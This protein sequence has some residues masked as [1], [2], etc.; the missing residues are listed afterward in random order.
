MFI[1]IRV[2]IHSSGLPQILSLPA[3]FLSIETVGIMPSHLTLTKDLCGAGEQLLQRTWFQFPE[4]TCWLKSICNSSFK[5]S[6][7][8]FWP[9]CVSDTQMAH[10]HIRQTNTHMHKV[11]TNKPLKNDYFICMSV[12]PS[13]MYVHHMCAWCPWSL[14]EGVWSPG[15]VVKNDC[16]SPCR[17]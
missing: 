6:N 11:K 1:L 15:T 8:L 5:D 14:E 2:S 9:S 13:C 4:L 12:L 7:T 3:C 10:I 17:C 16:E